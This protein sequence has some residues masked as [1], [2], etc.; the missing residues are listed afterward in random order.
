[1]TLAFEGY[2]KR[3]SARKAI[4]RIARKLVNRIFF[5]LKHGQQYVPCVVN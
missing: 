2:R 3:M 4:V 1:M 5:V